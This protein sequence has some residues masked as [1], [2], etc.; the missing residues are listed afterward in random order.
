MSTQRRSPEELF[1]NA[2]A[3]TRDQSIDPQIVAAARDRVARRL[4]AEL[5]G[6]LDGAVGGEVALERRDLRAEDEA[7]RIDDTADRRIQFVPQL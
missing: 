2:V 3:A 6:V 5:D 1:E 7:A 4:T